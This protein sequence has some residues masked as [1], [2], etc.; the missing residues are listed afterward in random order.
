MSVRRP[1]RCAGGLAILLWLA[2]AGSAL[3]H[4]SFAMFDHTRTLT[5]RGE[6]T[7]F[8]WTN[9]HAIL[10]I[11]VP[12]AGGRCH[13]LHAGIDEHQHDA[14]PRLALELHQGRRQGESRDGAARQR[15][16]RRPP[17]RGHAARRQNAGAGRAGGRHVQANAGRGVTP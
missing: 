5:L 9:P 6:V 1:L 7:K 16:A 13:A 15:R 10:E 8:Q 4:H 17:A 3:A 2:G 11:D 12:G 14:A